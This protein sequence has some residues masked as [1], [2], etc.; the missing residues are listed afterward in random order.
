M[1]LPL[2]THVTPAGSVAPVRVMVGTGNPVVVTVNVPGAPT[3]KVVAAALVIAGAVVT[4]QREALRRGGGPAVVR[5]NVS[6]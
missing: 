3:G 4:V 2:S 5:L 1:P 6:A